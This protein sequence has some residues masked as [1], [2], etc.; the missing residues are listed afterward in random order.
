MEESSLKKLS[1][2]KVTAGDP[3]WYETAS[4]V[5]IVTD[6]TPQSSNS[7]VIVRDDPAMVG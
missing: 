1:A 4:M 7:T 6:E 3:I 5:G 2:V